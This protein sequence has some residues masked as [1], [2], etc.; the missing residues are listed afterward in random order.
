MK[1]I[2]IYT[3]AAWNH[4]KKKK[5]FK[6]GFLICDGEKEEHYW[7][8]HNIEEFK[9][10]WMFEEEFNIN[11][12]EM[13]SIIQSIK[14]IKENNT[15]IN[16]YT[17]SMISFTVLNKISKKTYRKRYHLLIEEFKTIKNRIKCN[18]NIC[19]IPGHSDIYGNEIANNLCKK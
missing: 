16:I 13:F 4:C 5:H 3:D 14:K 19:W 11:F 18:V 6:L 8:I 1:T 17:D 9:N 10:K 7:Q 15:T 12:A 2:D